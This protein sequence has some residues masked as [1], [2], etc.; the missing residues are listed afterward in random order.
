MCLLPRATLHSDNEH[1]RLL[2]LDHHANRLP[3]HMC[4]FYDF[5]N[6]Y[7]EKAKNNKEKFFNLMNINCK[8]GFAYNMVITV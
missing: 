7:M 4:S 8:D 3:Y 2:G 1:F 6:I 5:G